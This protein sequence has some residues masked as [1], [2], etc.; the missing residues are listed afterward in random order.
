[1]ASFSEEL[2]IEMTPFKAMV[3]SPS[4]DEYIPNDEIPKG[5]ETL[6]LSGT[7]L[8]ARLKSGA[9]RCHRI[10]AFSYAGAKT[11]INLCC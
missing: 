3:Y 7:E 1:M 6:D 10:L 8:R 11:N 4:L 9:V 2:N 5:M